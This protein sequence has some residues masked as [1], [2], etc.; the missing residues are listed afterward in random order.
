M[1][2]T[3]ASLALREERIRIRF[4]TFDA[5]CASLGR[6][7]LGHSTAGELPHDAH[8][9][10]AREGVAPRS[11]HSRRSNYFRSLRTAGKL[12]ARTLAGLRPHR[13]YNNPPILH[14]YYTSSCWWGASPMLSA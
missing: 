8:S 3:R 9:P 10:R 7:V 14:P 13:Q 5:Q 11:W 4:P 6:S 2:P 1:A 12:G